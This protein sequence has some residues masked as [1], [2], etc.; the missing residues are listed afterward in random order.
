MSRFALVALIAV[1]TAGCGLLYKQPIYQGNLIEQSAIEQLQVGMDKQQVLTLLGSPSIADPFH[2]QRWDYTATE[3]TDRRGRTEVKNMTLWFENDQ[4]AR[5]EGEY[6][7]E[8]D[9]ELS[10]RMRRFGNLPR[11]KGNQRR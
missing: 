11:E 7:A 6:F 8:Q 2:H 3:R 4:L 5:W 10:E 1:A 9:K